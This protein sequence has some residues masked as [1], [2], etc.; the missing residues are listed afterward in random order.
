MVHKLSDPI[1]ISVRRRLLGDKDSLN[2]DEAGAWMPW[3]YSDF[4]PA[5]STLSRTSTTAQFQMFTL[6]TFLRLAFFRR[7]GS[8]GSNLTVSFE[9][10]LKLKHNQLSRFLVFES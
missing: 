7:L 2:G 9:K 4:F 6:A 3:N 8:L 1:K 5:R 10:L